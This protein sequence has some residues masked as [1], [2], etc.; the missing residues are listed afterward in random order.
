MLGLRAFE[1]LDQHRSICPEQKGNH[2]FDRLEDPLFGGAVG[3]ADAGQLGSG[4]REQDVTATTESFANLFAYRGILD[5]RHERE[6]VREIEGRIDLRPIDPHHESAGADGAGGLLEP[7]PWPA[8]EIHHALARLQEAVVPL[9]LRELVD[10]SRAE[11]LAFGALVE[12]VFAVVAGDGTY[13][14]FAATARRIF[15]MPLLCPG[16]APSTKSRLF[17]ASTRTTFRFWTV[18]RTWPM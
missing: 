14:F 16:T 3:L 11:A 17:S 1:Q 18:T 9:Q 7:A 5:V 4:I 6:H 13:F 2:R 10:G 15:T 8:T 12:V